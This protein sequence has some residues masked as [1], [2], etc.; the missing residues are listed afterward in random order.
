MKQQNLYKPVQGEKGGAGD[1]L[2]LSVGFGIRDGNQHA[3][4]QFPTCSLSLI[5]VTA[6]K[7]NELE[8]RAKR[9][10]DAIGNK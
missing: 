10:E 5:D 7:I 8:R 6:T 4:Q 1:Y 3:Q 2:I 9:R